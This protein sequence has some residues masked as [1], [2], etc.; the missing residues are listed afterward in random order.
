MDAIKNK[1]LKNFHLRPNVTLSSKPASIYESKQ[2]LST[3]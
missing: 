3:Q 2:L 1:V